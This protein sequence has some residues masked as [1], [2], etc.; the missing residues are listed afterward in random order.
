[1]TTG[2]NKA[3]KT[4]PKRA[5]RAAGEGTFETLPSGL[6]RCRAL[7][8]GKK[9]SG[10]GTTKKLAADDLKRAVEDAKNGVSRAKGKS[11]GTLAER[12]LATKRRYSPT[13]KEV[14]GY[15]IES[16]K[17]DL[18]GEMPVNK[19][20]ELHLEKWKERQEMA[21]STLR[22]RCR[23]L[24]QVL[25]Y[26][27]VSV[28]VKIPKKEDHERRPLSPDEQA[29]ARDRVA[30]ADPKVRL[31]ALLGWL[32]GLRRSELCGLMYEDRD[33]NGF[34]IKRSAVVTKGK[35]VIRPKSS[36]SRKKG[37]WVPFPES[38]LNEIGEGTGFILGNGKEPMNPKSLT[39]A[40]EALI[41]GTVL[42]EIPYMGLHAFRRT[43]G[44]TLLETGTDVVTAATA[45]R[46]DPKM[47]MEEYA[48][49][50][51]DLMT[52][53]VDRAFGTAKAA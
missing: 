20:T 14:T 36:N 46:H 8:N 6:I 13:T 7:V 37:G 23:F 21:N 39:N 52:S 28:R 38:L 47:L 44:M 10:K 5:K 12:W 41:K 17:A 4:K 19:I 18:L 49:T 40:I 1:M 2:S 45:M 25:A 34:R 53:A 3:T 48:R 24:N 9:V 16:L 35:I 26:G 11:F 32:G 22:N 30:R 51:R 27:G 31:G 15:W 29:V 33:G 42:E 43:F 50:R